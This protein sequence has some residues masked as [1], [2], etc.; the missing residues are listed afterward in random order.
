MKTIKNC[1]EDCKDYHSI[2]HDFGIRLY[3]ARFDQD[4]DEELIEKCDRIFDP[5]ITKPKERHYFVK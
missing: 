4:L 1:E 5:Q 3:C 2:P